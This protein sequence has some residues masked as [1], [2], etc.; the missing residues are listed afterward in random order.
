[1]LSRA[2]RFLTSATC[3]TGTRATS[4]C[5]APISGSYTV[6]QAGTTNRPAGTSSSAHLLS[7]QRPP[8][9]RR[10]PPSTVDN[11][12]QSASGQPLPD[13]S[14]PIRAPTDVPMNDRLTGARSLASL[15]MRN[16]SKPGL[17]PHPVAC[18]RSN[19]V[20]NSNRLKI[21]DAADRPLDPLSMFAQSRRFHPSL[22]EDE[23]FLLARFRVHFRLQ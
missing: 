2:L 18:E 20:E 16:D 14:R 19:E 12:L 21:E 9:Q 1:M 15:D 4:P 17:L 11:V 3:I 13:S 23:S 10:R 5:G 7:A 6:D 22:D 8:T